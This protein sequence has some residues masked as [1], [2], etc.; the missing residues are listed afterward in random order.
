MGSVI[1]T[2]R[3][4]RDSTDGKLS[5]DNNFK[6]TTDLAEAIGDD[7]FGCARGLHIAIVCADICFL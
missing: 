5:E 2:N 7:F 4:I 6:W 1:F 3:L